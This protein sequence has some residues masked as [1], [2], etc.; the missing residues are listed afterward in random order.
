MGLHW[1]LVVVVVVTAHPSLHLRLWETHLVDVLDFNGTTFTLYNIAG[2]ITFVGNLAFS[3]VGILLL[4][5]TLDA[6]LHF[7]HPILIPCVTFSSIISFSWSNEHRYL[8]VTLM[9][10]S[11]MKNLLN[12]VERIIG[13]M[14]PKRKLGVMFFSVHLFLYLPRT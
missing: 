5:N 7:H 13:N 2:L 8:H 4:H 6:L 1:V 12:M 3:L 11:K 9:H 14:R 10:V